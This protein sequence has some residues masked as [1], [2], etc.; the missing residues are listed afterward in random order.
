MAITGQVCRLDILTSILNAVRAAGRRPALT[1]KQ[2]ALIPGNDPL[3]RFLLSVF[4]SPL[5]WTGKTVHGVLE[6]QAED[7]MAEAV[8]NTAQFYIRRMHFATYSDLK[9]LLD[10]VRVTLQHLCG[11]G[12]Q[13]S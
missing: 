7:D 4:S 5:S 10:K 6:E 3:Q 12:L 2:V 11:K 13:A 9:T 1:P 8:Q